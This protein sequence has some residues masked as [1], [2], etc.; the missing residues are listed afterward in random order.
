ASRI[1]RVN[2]VSRSV[3]QLVR[4]LAHLKRCPLE[5]LQQERIGWAMDRHDALIPGS[6]RRKTDPNLDLQDLMRRITPKKELAED[7]EADPSGH[8]EHWLKLSKTLFDSEK[9]PQEG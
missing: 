2:R 6:S 3:T 7:V 8:V 4:P 1:S 5:S 9:E